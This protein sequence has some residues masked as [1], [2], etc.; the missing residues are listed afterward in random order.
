MSLDMITKS[1][2][3]KSGLLLLGLDVTRFEKETRT[4]LDEATFSKNNS[5]AFYYILHLL[6]SNLINEAQKKKYLTC[7][8]V[9]TL[10]D[11]IEFKEVS[12]SLIRE[13]E[14][15]N[16]IPK[17]FI[18]SKSVLDVHQGEKTISFLKFLCEIALLTQVRQNFPKENPEIFVLNSKNTTLDSKHGSLSKEG[19]DMNDYF[20][21]SSYQDEGYILSKVNASSLARAIK[22]CS[23]HIE[24]QSQKLLKQI[25]TFQKD[26]KAYRE[27][28]ALVY[29]RFEQIKEESLQLIQNY[30]KFKETVPKELFSEARA[31]DR[32]PLLDYLRETERRIAEV[33]E[34]AE[35]RD[36][37]SKWQEYELDSRK[38]NLL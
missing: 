10:Q 12:L 7:Y 5:K 27:S 24:I 18:L 9:K 19:F 31:L 11:A 32:I 37:E 29:K 28:A 2:L 26:S 17:N 8:P 25:R 6:L 23:I 38:D 13:L 36:F 22:A 3:L 20:L 16:R 30:K 15:E 14:E 21:V 34:L 33:K 1:N 35:K 4:P